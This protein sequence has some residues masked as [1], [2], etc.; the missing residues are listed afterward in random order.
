[1]LVAHEHHDRHFTLARFFD[2]VDQLDGGQRFGPFVTGQAQGLGTCHVVALEQ[3]EEIVGVLELRPL[4]AQGTYIDF[5]I[6]AWGI[7]FRQRLQRGGLP[8][9][10]CEVSPVALLSAATTA[11]PGSAGVAAPAKR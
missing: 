8:P 10:G 9:L 2:D 7:G 11:A 5:T 3:H 6:G 1:M 4:A